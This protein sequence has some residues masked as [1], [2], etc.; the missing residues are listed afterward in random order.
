MPRLLLHL[1]KHD[2]GS[3]SGIL[4]DVIISY[5]AINGAFIGY[6]FVVLGS[7]ANGN[8]YPCL[9]VLSY[10]DF[11]DNRSVFDD[12]NRGCHFRLS[13]VLAHRSFASSHGLLAYFAMFTSGCVHAHSTSPTTLAFGF[14]LEEMTFA[15]T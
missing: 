3:H 5:H 10:S 7:R 14:C 8:K 1:H 6:Y 13:A 9:S 4:V 11:R 12:V 2:L 15:R